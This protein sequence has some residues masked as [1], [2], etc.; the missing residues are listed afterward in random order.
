MSGTQYVART[1]SLLATAREAQQSVIA[2][3]HHAPRQEFIER[4]ESEG[5]RYFSCGCYSDVYTKDGA[6]F[7]VK[8]GMQGKAKL[9]GYLPYAQWLCD[10]QKHGRDDPRATNPAFP[11][12]YGVTLFD[13]CWFVAVIERLE[14]L[15]D[16]YSEKMWITARSLE[17]R[18]RGPSSSDTAEFVENLNR[19][20]ETLPKCLLDA[21]DM[22]RDVFVKDWSSDI[23]PANILR[24]GD[25]LV[26]ADPLEV[27]LP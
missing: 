19:F 5:W 20:A 9:D 11:R 16:K 12:V 2:A 22:I 8:V 15:R 24:R 13:A 3:A 1:P 4:L 17:Q 18:V 26:I 23:Q 27:A 21:A 10:G 14:V 6:P 25:Q 7:V